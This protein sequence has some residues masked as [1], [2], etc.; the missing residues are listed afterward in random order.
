MECLAPITLWRKNGPILAKEFHSDVV[1]CGKCPSCLRRRQAGWTF[2]LHQEQ[3]ISRSAVFLTMTYD[4]ENLPYSTAGY[5]TLEKI[6]HQKFLK[7]LRKTINTHFKHETTDRI[8]YYSC[9][10]YGENTHRPHYHSIMYNL[11]SSYIKHPE[12]ITKDWQ[13]GQTMLAV[14]NPATIAYVTKYINKTL[15]ITGQDD[16][17]DRQKEFSLMSKGLGKNYLTDG[18]IN[19]YKKILTPY[20]I[21]ENGD[22]STMPRYYKDKLYDD[23]QKTKINEKTKLHLEENPVFLSDK[24]RQDYIEQQFRKHKLQQQILRQTL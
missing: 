12:L 21:T 15:Y 19:Y 8:K 2:R 22:K 5:P 20:L 3:L 18:R 24:H 13:H 1:P 6:H 16:Q 4:N 23:S 11:P 9:G 14:C 10:E 7:R 17:D